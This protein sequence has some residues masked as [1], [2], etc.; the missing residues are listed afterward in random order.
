MAGR[1]RAIG[2]WPSLPEDTKT[3]AKAALASALH[4]LL[5]SMPTSMEQDLTALEDGATGKLATAI[6]YRLDRK[7]LLAGAVQAL[8]GK[9]AAKAPRLHLTFKHDLSRVQ[10]EQAASL[11]QWHSSLGDDAAAEKAWREAV[12]LDPKRIDAQTAMGLIY[13]QQGHAGQAREHFTTALGMVDR[14]REQRKWAKAACN[15]ADATLQGGEAYLSVQLYRDALKA[16][17]NLESCQHNMNQ[18]QASM[19]EAEAEAT[20]ASQSAQAKA[21]ATTKAAKAKAE[22]KPPAAAGKAEL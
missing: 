10:A 5:Q 7:K 14:E 13:L 2:E 11:A 20:K 15:L 3:K 18:A 4:A 22:A 12:G 16:D 17:P 19:T 6:R 9:P 8:G 21:S 1:S